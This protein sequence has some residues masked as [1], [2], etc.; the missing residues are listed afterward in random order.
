MLLIKILALVFL[1]AAVPIPSPAG[2]DNN[3][4][5]LQRPRPLREPTVQGD[6]SL[7]GNTGKM[8]A[9]AV[10][11]RIIPPP[12]VKLPPPFLSEF[13]TYKFNQQ[14]QPNPPTPPPRVCLP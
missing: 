12:Q 10:K 8:S 14:Q 5:K 13:T 11:N 6:N 7:G 3:P 9:N 1:V 2:P 4:A